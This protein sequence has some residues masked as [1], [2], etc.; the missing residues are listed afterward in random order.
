MSLSSSLWRRPHGRPWPTARSFPRKSL[1][2]RGAA[3][4]R[5]RLA[6]RERRLPA[7]ASGI[8]PRR[9]DDP[10]EGRPD[11]TATTTG[12]VDAG[13]VVGIVAPPPRSLGHTRWLAASVFPAVIGVAVLVLGLSGLTGSS[14]GSYATTEAGG[15]HPP[16]LLAGSVRGI[17]SDEWLVRTP[18]V[19]RQLE[20]GLPHRVAGGVGSHDAAVLMDL[21]TGGWEV[22]LRPHTAVYR[23]LG[24]EQAFAVEWWG[25]FAIQLLGVYALVLTLT[26]RIAVSALAA[27]LVTLSPATQWWTTPATFTA[28]GYGC[29]ATALVLRAYRT[30][31]ARRRVALSALAGLILADFL[32]GIYPPWQIGT[33]LVLVPVAVASVVPDLW[34]SA[35]RLRAVRSL[36]LVV[37]IVLGVAGAL[38]GSFLSEHRGAVTAISSTVYPGH[39]SAEHGGGA[40]LPIV[41]GS[42]FDSFA[43]VKPYAVVN[44]TNQSENASGLPL[45]LPVAVAGLAL[46]AWRR[47]RGS[48]SSP[49]LIG[50][51]MGGALVVAWMLLPIPSQVGR[52]L[53]LTRVPPYR[54]SLPLCLAGAIGLALLVCH[55]SESERPF[56]RTLLLACVAG[57]G[58]ALAW[59]A[60]RYTVDGAGIDTRRAAVF[61]LVAMVG[62]ALALS[63]RPLPGLAVLVIFSLWQASLINPVQRGL[64]PLTVNP[65]R[66]A[67]DSVKASAP[68]EA[69]WIAYSVDLTVRGILTAAGV[70]NLAGVSPYP[71]RAAWQVLDPR[72]ASEAAWNRYAHV[73]FTA[74]PAGAAPSFTL[75]GPDN[76]SVAV[77]PCGAALRQLGVR[78][79][80]AHGL[81][82][83]T[84]LS[85]VVTVRQ[86]GSDVVV[87]RYG[88]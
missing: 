33:A 60:A 80:V 25:F 8:H 19:L 83:Q 31:T 57:F 5:T 12:T 62:V 37:P 23:F 74:A 65:L 2:G 18:W 54:L 13:G 16:G 15:A 48:R 44:G 72:R 47:L 22:V 52:F 42:A 66:H 79:V 86:G 6:G 4:A 76:L 36:V 21:P 88:P 7:V 53:L 50:C 56:P 69:G 51:L 35:T 68:A 82:P 70:N 29:L 24:D 10:L 14:L 1:A 87:Y 11:A 84:C 73:S 63:R 28:V 71:D 64:R 41:L 34:A 85:P 3:S 26:G 9:D 46:V 81:G 38:L 43:S 78:F 39:R 45:L 67:V 30:A 49:A 32:A 27:S 77:D 40:A 17:R 58:G 61:V 59:G 75:I 55:Q 20:L